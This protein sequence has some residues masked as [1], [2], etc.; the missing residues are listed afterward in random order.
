[1]TTDTTQPPA[2][3]LAAIDTLAGDL[4]RE[5]AEHPG[6][7]EAVCAVLLR[8]LDVLDTWPL[9]QVCMAAMRATYGRCLIPHPDSVPAGGL[10]V[11]ATQARSA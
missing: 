10:T 5:L 11:D 1:M 3:D 4:I 6:D 7:D 8:W 2:L 9:A